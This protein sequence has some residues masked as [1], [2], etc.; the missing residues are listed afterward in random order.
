MQCSAGPAAG[1]CGDAARHAR[2]LRRET[3]QCTPLTAATCCT[4]AGNPCSHTQHL[5]CTHQAIHAHVGCVGWCE[6]V[7]VV[8][9]EK[10]DTQL[11]EGD[12]HQGKACSEKQVDGKKEEGKRG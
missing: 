9:V 5:V 10:L 1:L 2:D 6:A 8:E 12:L 11:L 4:V 3:E 7:A